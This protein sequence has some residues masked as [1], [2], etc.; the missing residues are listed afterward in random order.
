MDVSPLQSYMARLKDEKAALESVLK[1]LKTEN[2]SENR[3]DDTDRWI[4]QVTVRLA[5]I[6]TALKALEVYRI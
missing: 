2:V 1:Q 6:D 5:A 3:I 4:E